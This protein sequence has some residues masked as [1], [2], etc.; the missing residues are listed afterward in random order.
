M[1][2]HVRGEVGGL[3]TRLEERPIAVVA[4]AG[5]LHYLQRPGNVLLLVDLHA[6]GRRQHLVRGEPL[7]IEHADGDGYDSLAQG[8]ELRQKSMH[9]LMVKNSVARLAT[10]DPPDPA[11]PPLTWANT[12]NR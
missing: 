8:A 4:E 11:A 10:S 9:L 5:G 2:G 12:G 7:F 3:A 1:V 6:F